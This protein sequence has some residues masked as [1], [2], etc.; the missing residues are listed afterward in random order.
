MTF[1]L[2][3]RLVIYFFLSPFLIF[4]VDARV[5]VCGSLLLL[6]KKHGRRALAAVFSCWLG[7]G[8]VMSDPL[9]I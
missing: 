3:K 7:M 9:F 1:R 2:E 8:L 4:A 5:L 6:R